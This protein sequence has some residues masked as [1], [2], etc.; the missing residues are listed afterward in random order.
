VSDQ[1]LLMESALSEGVVGRTN[2]EMAMRGIRVT[3]R[4]LNNSGEGS[5]PTNKPIRATRKL[6]TQTMPRSRQFMAHMPAHPWAEITPAETFPIGTRSA[7]ALAGGAL[8]VEL[9]VVCVP[10]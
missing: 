1:I 9:G 5:L 6:R 4:M 8:S 3:F 7:K 2:F 10:S